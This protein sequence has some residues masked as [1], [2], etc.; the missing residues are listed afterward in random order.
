MRG[1]FRQWTAIV[2]PPPSAHQ[3][4]PLPL[5][6]KSETLDGHQMCDPRIP[7]NE[8]HDGQLS[9]P[10]QF[11]VCTRLARFGQRH[12]AVRSDV[13]HQTT[14]ACRMDV[15]NMLAEASVWCT[16]D[17][18]MHWTDSV[19]SAG[20]T[21]ACKKLVGYQ[22]SCCKPSSLSVC[23]TGVRHTKRTR[24]Q[25]AFSSEWGIG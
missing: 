17:H 8:T 16:A 19:G 20:M 21:A 2:T 23:G 1:R 18:Q 14:L 22:P 3:T 4:P 25:S 24:L 6:T 9:P 10:P 12:S 7:P 5:A 15:T 11:F 13:H